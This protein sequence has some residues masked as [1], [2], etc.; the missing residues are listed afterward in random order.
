MQEVVNVE[1]RLSEELF[2]ALVFKG[3]KGSLDSSY[4]GCGDVSVG[5]GELCGVLCHIVQH[6]AQVFQIQKQE[7]TLVCNAED[8]IHYAG[9]GLVKL[10]HSGNQLRAHLGDGCAHGVTLLAKNVEEPNG[11]ALELRVFNTEL[12]HSLLDET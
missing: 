6:G 12:R 8:Y 11:T 4:A 1:R 7:A 2:C 9:L 3:K 10:Q 5:G